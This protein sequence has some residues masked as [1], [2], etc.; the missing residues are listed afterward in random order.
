MG[1]PDEVRSVSLQGD[2]VTTGNYFFY[3]LLVFIF[4]LLLFFFLGGRRSMEMGSRGGES[5]HL[6]AVTV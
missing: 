4:F 1:K 6:M 2:L 3:F 5:S